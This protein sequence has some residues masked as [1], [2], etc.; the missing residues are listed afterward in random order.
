MKV[1]SVDPAPYRLRQ[2]SHLCWTIPEVIRGAST[3][4]DVAATHELRSWE[5][6]LALDAMETRQVPN[7]AHT[8]AP[9]SRPMP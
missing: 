6:V 4:N 5:P 3:S 2:A 8:P 1:L 7:Q 9:P